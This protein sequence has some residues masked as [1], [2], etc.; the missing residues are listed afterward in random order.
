MVCWYPPKIG[1]VSYNAFASNGKVHSVLR[2]CRCCFPVKSCQ[3]REGELV[4]RVT[5]LGTD[6][7]NSS[8]ECLES[9]YSP[10]M[11]ILPGVI[12]LQVFFGFYKASP[13]VA[14][15]WHGI[16]HAR[17]LQANE[18]TRDIA[19]TQFSRLYRLSRHR[20]D[21]DREP[22][23]GL[24]LPLALELIRPITFRTVL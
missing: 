12:T 3:F 18:I 4:R 14:K 2:T 11:L 10:T 7:N 22:T 8:A 16:P 17:N 20:A 19:T 9:V 21:G 15:L 6:T 13:H 24:Q 23:W 5:A 1:A